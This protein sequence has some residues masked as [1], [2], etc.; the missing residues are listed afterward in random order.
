MWVRSSLQLSDNI[1]QL[2]TAVSVHLLLLGERS[3][4]VDASISAV[5]PRLIE[6]LEGVLG[7]AGQLDFLLI[8]HAHFDH[9][10][11]VP[12]LKERYPE[13][14]LIASPQTAELLSSPGVLEAVYEQN[15]QCAEATNTPLA[16][17]LE[18]FKG[19]FSFSQLVRDGDTLSFGDSVEVKVLSCTGHSSDSISFFIHPDGALA[20][21][22][23]LGHYAGRDKVIPCFMESFEDYLSSCDK[24]LNMEVKMLCLPHAG[25]L[26]GELP[27][28]YFTQ[29]RDEAKR[30]HDHIRARLEEGQLV[31]EIAS[32][33]YPDWLSAGLGPDGPFVQSTKEAAIKMVRVVAEAK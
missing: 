12:L 2:T 3:A 4:L 9:I 23:A 18:T 24:F 33:L 7:D 25:T 29:L 22:E 31:E 1:F 8:S 16:F 13:L 15:K 30:L 5:A 27:V 11:A 6:E 28:K 20:G 10:G 21:G 19:A 26:S 14:K 17:D 32:A